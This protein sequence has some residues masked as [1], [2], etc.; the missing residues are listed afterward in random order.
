MSFVLVTGPTVEPLTAAEARLR[1][2]IGAEMQDA[3]LNALITTA[4]MKIERQYGLAMVSQTLDYIRDTFPVVENYG[5]NPYERGF[6]PSQSY[7]A[8]FG[9]PYTASQGDIVL[10][11]T[12]VRSITSVSY[13]DYTGVLQTLDPSRYVLKKSDLY[14]SLSQAIQTTWP[15]TQFV[16]GSVK[17]RLVAGYG[18]DATAVPETLKTVVAL[19]VNH[20]RSMMANNIF[21]TGESVI[22]VASKN[23]SVG[24]P[25]TDVI[26]QAITAMMQ[27]YVRP[28]L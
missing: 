7:T 10:P 19:Y 11:V 8:N 16:S 26:D 20:L 4:R 24:R 9:R 1:L 18:D 3:T 14:S 22:G 2:N 6:Y 27:D 13:L 17:V 25:G 28:S 23:Y 21:L 5:L 15:V 12:P